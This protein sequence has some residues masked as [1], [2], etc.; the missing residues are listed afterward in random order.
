MDKAIFALIE[1]KRSKL[2]ATSLGALRMQLTNC[3]PFGGYSSIKKEIAV[4]TLLRY[5]FGPGR[6]DEFDREEKKC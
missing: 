5:I 2:Q 3:N 1:E 4:K 6:M